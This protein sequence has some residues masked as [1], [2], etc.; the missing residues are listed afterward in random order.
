[1]PDASTL[2]N[3]GDLYGPINWVASDAPVCP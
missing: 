1:V 2:K 3:N